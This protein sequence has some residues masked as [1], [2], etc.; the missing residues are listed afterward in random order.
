MGNETLTTI[1]RAYIVRE[2]RDG[3]DTIKHGSLD[4]LM[5]TRTGNKY[6]NFTNRCRVLAAPKGGKYA[7][8]DVVW[9][10]H[11]VLNQSFGDD[12][13]CAEHQ[14]WISGDRIAEVES[15]EL[16]VFKYRNI[17]E[18]T[19]PSGIFLVTFEDTDEKNMKGD[20]V[21]GAL[22]KGSVIE[23]IADNEYEFW[24]DEQQYLVVDKEHITTIDGVLTEG[25]YE[26]EKLTLSERQDLFRQH[27][28]MPKKG[29][30]ARLKNSLLP[31]HG[32]HCW[33]STSSAQR[34][35]RPPEILAILDLPS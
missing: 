13:Y 30:I 19:T 2:L 34:F 21:A 33:L 6:T 25:F 22:P 28:I 14:I 32:K 5:R 27:G 10:H 8:G 16:V 23:W 7:V 29:F 9:V 20:V 15:D 11:F 35:V 18:K 1:N 3:F 26:Y 24:Q 31:Y 12:L 4:L 17:S